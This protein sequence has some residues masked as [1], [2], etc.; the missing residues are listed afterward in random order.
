MKPAGVSR[1]CGKYATRRARS[2]W[3]S[4]RR[5]APAN[6]TVPP[7]SMIPVIKRKAVVLPLPLA[8]ISPTISPGPI[9]SETPERISRSPAS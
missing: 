6:R 7:P 3:E 5:L 9:L 8:P 2:R 4:S 1:T